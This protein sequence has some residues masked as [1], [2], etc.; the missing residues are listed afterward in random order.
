MN[1]TIE[2]V[3]DTPTQSPLP[4]QWEGEDLMQLEDGT[5]VDFCWRAP[6]LVEELFVNV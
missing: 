6:H 2:M 5:G 4:R 1:G 3:W